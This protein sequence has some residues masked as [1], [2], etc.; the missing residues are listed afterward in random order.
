MTS[1]WKSCS[2]TSILCEKMQIT[3]TTCSGCEHQEAWVLGGPSGEPSPHGSR[4][5]RDCKGGRRPH[6][7]DRQRKYFTGRRW[8]LGGTWEE[9]WIPP[10]KKES[11]WGNEHICSGGSGFESCFCHPLP[12]HVPLGTIHTG[13]LQRIAITYI[14]SLYPIQNSYTNQ[15]YHY[16][17]QRG[18]SKLGKNQ[19]YKECRGQ[20]DDLQHYGSIIQNGLER[21]T[22]NK[23]LDST[24][25]AFVTNYTS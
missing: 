8:S 16:S 11:S 19:R 2:V 22:Y 10:K 3:G 13:C 4:W 15:S 14:K 20:S 24:V 12:N 17:S 18:C 23:S 6:E 25:S 9:M 1:P 7:G 5:Q 21:K